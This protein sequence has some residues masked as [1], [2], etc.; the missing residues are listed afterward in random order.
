MEGHGGAVWS[1]G[2]SGDGRHVVS[3]SRD[4]TVRV[5]EVGSGREV[6]KM[7]G[8]GGDVMSV[9]V[10]AGGRRGRAGVGA[11]APG[12]GSSHGR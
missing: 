1:V 2:Y 9:G 6:M 12:G 7:E 5:W 3:G 10:W 8:H 11:A 4:G